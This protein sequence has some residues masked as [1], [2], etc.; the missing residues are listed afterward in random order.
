MKKRLAGTLTCME[1]HWENLLQ[2]AQTREDTVVFSELDSLV[3]MARFATEKLLL[4]WDMNLTD[5]DIPDTVTLDESD[6]NIDSTLE[7][8]GDE[9][10]VLHTQEFVA[11][12]DSGERDIAREEKTTPG[13]PFHNAALWTI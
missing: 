13:N 6:D 10:A 3:Q 9:N 8:V 5:K 11:M 12:M 7:A 2:E 1:G 4:Y